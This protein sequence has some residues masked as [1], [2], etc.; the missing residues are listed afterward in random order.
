MGIELT[1]G[2]PSAR[3]FGLRILTMTTIAFY[4]FVVSVAILMVSLDRQSISDS[5]SSES[6]IDKWVRWAGI[7]LFWVALILYVLISVELASYQ[8]IPAMVVMALVITYIF[9]RA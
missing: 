1:A 2:E 9:R 4:V 3:S 5:Q 7:G 8:Y 6:A